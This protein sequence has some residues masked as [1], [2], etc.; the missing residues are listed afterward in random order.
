MRETGAVVTEYTVGPKFLADQAGAHER[1]I[2]FSR[3]PDDLAQFVSILDKYLQHANYYYGS[4]RADGKLIQ[5]PIVHLAPPGTFKQRMKNKNKLGG[6]AKI[7]QLRND[8]EYI[9][10]LLVLINE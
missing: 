8:R 9:E 2:E 4:K 7:P 3:Q 6:Q 5:A 1:I 10:E